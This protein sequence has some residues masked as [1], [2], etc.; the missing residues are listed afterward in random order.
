MLQKSSFVLSAYSV[1]SL[2]T[3][4]KRSNRA[5]NAHIPNWQY[6]AEIKGTASTMGEN[7]M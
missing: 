3:G 2:R 1:S 5:I 4:D 7:L 6:K